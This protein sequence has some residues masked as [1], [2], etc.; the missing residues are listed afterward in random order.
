MRT[1]GGA[2]RSEID[3]RSQCA[4]VRDQGSRPTCVPCAASD[5]H[6]QFQKCAPLSVEYLFYQSVK[7]SVAKDPSIGLTFEE[8][9]NALAKMGQP[10]EKE[11][12]YPPPT[13][14]WTPANHAC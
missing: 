9:R 5:A 10:L 6:A 2:I 8:V 3:L 13:L 11:W 1:V 14:Q 12:P 7:H 4:N